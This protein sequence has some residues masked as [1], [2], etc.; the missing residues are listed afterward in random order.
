[1]SL[2]VKVCSSFPVSPEMATAGGAVAGILPD[3]ISSIGA[4][5]NSCNNKDIR[6]HEITKC[7]EVENNRIEKDYLDKCNQW[8]FKSRLMHNA[9]TSDKISGDQIIEL[10]KE[11]LK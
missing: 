11:C 9:F 6:I 4:I 8:A 2:P 1:M 7:A 10:A 3:I 5:V